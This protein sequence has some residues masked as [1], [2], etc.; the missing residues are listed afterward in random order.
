MIPEGERDLLALL[1]PLRRGRGYRLY[2]Q[3][4]RRF[5]DLWVQGGWA[6]L[7]HSSHRQV[8]L[9][10]NTL[11]RGCLGLFP[12]D[13]HHRLYQALASI[14]PD[15]VFRIYRSFERLRQLELWKHRKNFFLGEALLMQQENPSGLRGD[16]TARED[17]LLSK[18]LFPAE[19]PRALSATKNIF[20]LSRLFGGVK[21]ESLCPVAVWRPFG[22]KKKD[23]WDSFP[24]LVLILP[25]GGLFQ[26]AVLAIRKE[27]DETRLP[28]SDIIP[29]PLETFLIRGVWDLQ[30]APPLDVSHLFPHT[31]QVVDNSGTWIR[32]GPYVW[33]RSPEALDQYALI[34]KVFLDEG[35]LLPPHPALPLILPRQATKGEDALLAKLLR[36]HA[37]KR[38]AP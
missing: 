27:Y 38:S 22:G 17:S 13:H 30:H 34:F 29:P 14:F 26:P 10:K 23:F 24:V 36:E 37:E 15:R 6:I 2:A 21:K 9:L 12:Q 1:P 35:V 28:P 33:Y 5:L 32:V 8:L 16:P 18:E 20:T 31:L 7:G 19:N 11:S 3:N 25:T 4:G